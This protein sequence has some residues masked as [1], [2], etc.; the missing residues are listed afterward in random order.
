M[1]DITVKTKNV[2]NVKSV[3]GHYVFL[4]CYFSYI[5]TAF[6]I[7]LCSVQW[8]R[9]H[10]ATFMCN[11]N[12]KFMYYANLPFSYYSQFTVIIFFDNSVTGYIAL[13]CI[14]IT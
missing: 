9:L 8:G 14:T 5:L 12:Y 1:M 2:E 7:S 11:I 6:I 10:F 13:L 3:I 4:F